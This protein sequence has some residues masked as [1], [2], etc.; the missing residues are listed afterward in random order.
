MEDD[1]YSVMAAGLGSPL[2]MK[3]KGFG[4]EA[5]SVVK[6]CL[7]YTS[8]MDV[9]NLYNSLLSEHPAYKYAYDMQ[10]SVSNLSLIHICKAGGRA[11]AQLH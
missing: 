11:G 8:K 10:V 4:P 1:E 6:G 9:Q 5:I 7:L 2:A 3:E